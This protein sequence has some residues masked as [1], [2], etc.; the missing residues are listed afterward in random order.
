MARAFDDIRRSTAF[1]RLLNIIQEGLPT[2]EE[3]KQ[4]SQEL[5][6]RIDEIKSMSR[7]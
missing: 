3:L 5:Q 2:D 1:V 7:G 6:D 4:F